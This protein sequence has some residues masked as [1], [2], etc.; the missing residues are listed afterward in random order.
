MLGKNKQKP[1]AST[2]IWSLI[3]SAQRQKIALRP[4]EPESV[5]AAPG[6]RVKNEFGAKSLRNFIQHRLQSV[7]GR[8]CELDG[9][10]S[11]ASGCRHRINTSV[12]NV[13]SVPRIGARSIGASPKGRIR[14]SHSDIISMEAVMDPAGVPTV[15]FIRI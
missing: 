8:G 10:I 13:S 7:D 12:F 9:I 3:R 15:C 11:R 2:M 5:T 14:P 4:S 6:S 1:P